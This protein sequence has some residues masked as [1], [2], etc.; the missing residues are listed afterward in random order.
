[1][2]DNLR[3]LTAENLIEIGVK[4]S[5]DGVKYGKFRNAAGI[6]KIYYLGGS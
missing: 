4:Q 5:K 3:E 1:M 6:I 2:K